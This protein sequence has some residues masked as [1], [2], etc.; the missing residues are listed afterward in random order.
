MTA[1][2]QTTKRSISVIIPALNETANIVRAVQAAWALSPAEVI[3]VDGGSSDA[4]VELVQQTEATLIT[5]PRGRALQLNAGARQATGKLLLFLHADTFLS[6]EAGLQLENFLQQVEASPKGSQI[7]AFCQRIDA[8]QWRYRLLEWGNRL[9]VQWRGTPYGDQGIFILRTLFEELGGF[10]EVPLMEEVLFIRNFKKYLAQ[11]AS[12]E[13]NSK[14]AVSRQ[15]GSGHTGRPVLLAG[16]LIISPRRWQQNG[17]LRQ[18]VHNWSLLIRERFG[19]PLE[20]LAG[21]YLPNPSEN[22]KKQS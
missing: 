4:T 11:V 17:V 9:R 8:P 19:V 1:P 7:G 3:V 20:R 5:S 12:K 6:S 15:A 22:K 18:T 2:L 16:P 14:D 21:E 13:A 10:P